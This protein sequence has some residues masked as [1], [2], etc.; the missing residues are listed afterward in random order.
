MSFKGDAMQESICSNNQFKETYLDVLKARL[1][2]ASLEVESENKELTSAIQTIRMMGLNNAL[3]LCLDNKDEFYER[4]E[5][6]NYTQQIVKMITCGENEKFRTSNVTVIGSKIR[7][8]EPYNIRQELLNII[9]NYNYQKAMYLDK[10]K[11]QSLIDYVAAEDELFY[12]ESQFHIEFLKIHPFEDG[13]GRTARVILAAN[14]L[15]NNHAPCIVTKKTKEKYCSYIEN[16]DI[17]G[18]AIFLKELS[19]QEKSNI[20]S[21][22]SNLAENNMTLKL[23][24]TE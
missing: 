13:N 24:K 1:T 5:F 19:L 18:M 22:Y 20:E 2:L 7:R 3:K 17:V 16:N 6:L 15:N 23:K 8:A 21:I 14:L 4:Y 11:N 12:I 9:D 10:I